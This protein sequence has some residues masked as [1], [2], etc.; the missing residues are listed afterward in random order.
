M[1]NT[2][3]N[4]NKKISNNEYKESFKELAPPSPSPLPSSSGVGV[5]VAATVVVVV[6]CP[7]VVVVVVAESMH[8]DQRWPLDQGGAIHFPNIS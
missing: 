6:S 8:K 1:L 5:V 4:V 7:N 2:I 3:H